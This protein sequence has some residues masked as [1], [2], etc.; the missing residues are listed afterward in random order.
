MT[1]ESGK[2]EILS[3]QNVVDVLHTPRPF[4]EYHED[5]GDVLWY[6]MPIEAPPWCGTPYD[7]DWPFEDDDDGELWWV[8]L[9]DSE[10]IH[11]RWEAA[12]KE[13]GSG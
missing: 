9:P 10:E 12:C 2:L 3:L 8:P 4:A 13:T 11:K 1:S 7:S 5:H 6:L